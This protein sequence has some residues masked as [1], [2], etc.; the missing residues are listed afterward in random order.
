MNSSVARCLADIE[1]GE[2]QEAMGV[3]V[4]PLF[5][6]TEPGMSYLALKTALKTGTIAVS[7]VSAAGVVG[8]IRVRNTGDIPVLLL[9]GEEISGAKQNRVLNT[10]ILVD[11]HTDII[12]PV[13]CTEQG[14]W[15]DVSSNFQESL[16]VAPPRLR[17]T[18]QRTVTTS[19]GEGQSF[20]ADQGEVWEEVRRMA[21]DAGVHSETGAMRD[22]FQTRM[23][24]LDAILQRFSFHPSQCG[25]MVAAGGDILGF[26]FVSRP[27]VYAVL[28]T[29]L[30][31]SY[32]MDALLGNRK[33]GR[34]VSQE[35]AK[36]FLHATNSAQETSYK[37]AGVGC[38]YRYT[39]AHMV[40]SAIA[41]DTEVVHTAFFAV[42]NDEPSASHDH[43]RSHVSRRGFRNG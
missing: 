10:A 25:L 43:L 40:G 3:T 7:E 19:L 37:S 27:D 18:T 26:D 5:T 38:D 9:D 24:D 34:R 36:G 17:R 29:K 4:F 28:H 1:L 2:P 12:I 31:R 30:V 41:L 8:N 39:G 33:S 22:I 32:A 14:R 20:R 42:P 15:T 13:S 16:S 23:P 6:P 11:A 21:A 35:T